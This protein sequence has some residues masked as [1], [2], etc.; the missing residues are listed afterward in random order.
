V[1]GESSEAPEYQQTSSLVPR[2][3]EIMINREAKVIDHCNRLRP[4]QYPLATLYYLRNCQVPMPG[5]DR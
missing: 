3:R 4:R 5:G 1:D 2:R